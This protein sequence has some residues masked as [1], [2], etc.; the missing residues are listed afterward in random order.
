MQNLLNEL[1]QL[2]Q[3]DERCVAEGELLKNKV[4]ELAL[5]VD[6]GLI[7]LLLKNKYIKK[8]F[9]IDTDGVLVFDKI[10]FQHF[11]S[12][13]EFLP[14]SYTAFK[15]KIGL[16]NENSDYLSE[17]R[18]V[19]IAWPYK[20][21]VL[22]GG[23]TKED[24]KRDEIFWNETLAPDEID[25]LLAPKVFTSFKK[26]DNRGEHLLKGNEKID[27][28]TENLIIRGNNLLALHSLVERFPSGVKLIYIDPPY[29][30]GN[31][32]FRY[33]DNFNHS[34]WLSF[35]KNRL[36]VARRMLKSDGVIVI[37]IDERELAYVKICA[38]EVFGRDHFLIQVNWQRTTQRSVLGQGATPIIN[39]MEYLLFYVKDISYK[40]KAL[41]KTQKLIPSSDKMYNQYN[42]QLV[43]E[44]TRKLHK[45]IEHNGQD[46]KIYKHKDFILKSIPSK[47]R[48]ENRYIELFETIV[49]KDSQQQES[50][51]EQVVINSIEKNDTLFSVE[52]VLKQGKHKG[53]LKKSLYMNDNVIYYLKEY[54]QV[55]DGKIL[56]T[57]DMNNIW[58]DNEISSAGIADEGGVKLKRGKKPE[59]LIKR[60]IEVSGCS[61]NDLILDFHL[62]SGTTASVA[63]KLGIRY[64]G[65]EQLDY[66]NNDSIA[67]IKNVIKGDSSGISK[68]VNWQG[69]GS[70]VHCELMEWNELYVSQI[71]KAKT[72]KE[73]LVLWDE[74]QSK[75]FISYKVNPQIIND[76]ITDFKDLSLA[77][78]KKF[79]IEVLDKNQLYVNYSEINDKEYGVS[80][81]D[82]KLNRQFYGEA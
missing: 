47:E 14:D 51:L 3:Q 50:S 39:I 35:M 79:L 26:Y 31:D 75:A 27:F 68:A 13:K 56:R 6:A 17:S 65:V 76:N 32:E 8:H 67:R 44:G 57:V 19:V 11:V 22:E 29:N 53:E 80:E 16:A 58:L 48:T 23:Q 62:G 25:R 42:L 71:K 12:N 43:S 37:Q 30:T 54:G 52:R 74:M 82:K 10:K 59:E 9:F 72:S 69:G 45:T 28:T 15:N 20:D 61:K 24:Q 40:D 66:G 33:N 49:R 36:E 41:V 34:T 81:T 63:H 55:V 21:C 7:K 1:K 4:I 60:I 73:L 2:L 70:F 5:A 38:D 64:I 78:Q 18:E 77:D 46:I